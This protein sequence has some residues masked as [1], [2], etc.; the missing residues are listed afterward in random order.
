MVKYNVFSGG[1][2]GP[3][4]YGT[5][6]WHFYIRNLLI[7]FN[8]WFIL[9]LLSFPVLLWQHFI[10][11]KPTVLRGIV[12]LAPFY[13]W[14]VIFTLQPHKE[15]RFMYPAY[16]ALALNAA[17]ALHMVLAYFGSTDPRDIVSRVPPG[18][19]FG[20]VSFVI[21]GALNL[22]I[23]RTM[24]LV[25]GYAAPLQVYS[26]L[27][28]PGVAFPGDYLCLGKEW[29]RF[30]SSYMLPD[31]VKAKFIRSEFNGL[32]PGEFSEAGTGSGFYPGSWMPPSGMNDQNIEDPGKYVCNFS[33]STWLRKLTLARLTLRDAN[34]SSIPDSKV[35]RNP[36]LNRIILGRQ[37]SGSL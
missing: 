35:H 25:T 1:S 23:L 20:V 9:A 28:D 36:H 29:Y 21:L 30:P 15:E 5:E 31:G 33:P 6:P 19:K 18:I 22:G 24:N 17:I 2:R 13:M 10:R 37:I 14:L 27:R 32:L 12:F 3:D 7:N 11:R 34:S 8:L 4:I 26:P 16:P